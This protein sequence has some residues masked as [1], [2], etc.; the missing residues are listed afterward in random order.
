MQ[1]KHTFSLHIQKEN[2][3]KNIRDRQKEN[4][5]VRQTGQKKSRQRTRHGKNTHTSSQR[6]LGNSHQTTRL[7]QNHGKMPRRPRTTLPNPRKNEEKSLDSRGRHRSSFSLG[8]SI[9]CPRRHLRQIQ[10][11]PDGLAEK[12]RVSYDADINAMRTHNRLTPNRKV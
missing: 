4:R 7:R 6:C 8:L 12:S 2:K 9:R 5:S 1:S 10:K 3:P 11:K